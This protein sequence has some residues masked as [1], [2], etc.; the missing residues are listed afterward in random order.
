[1]IS[2][3]SHSR[4]VTAASAVL[5]L[6]G[7]VALFF[8]QSTVE[9]RAG[10]VT[11]PK[12]KKVL[13]IG[14]DGCRSD[15][16]QAAD[17]PRLKA[18]AA[19]GTVTWNAVA[20]GELNGPTQQPTVSGPGWSSILC[21]VCM[22]KHRIFDNKFIGHQLERYP[23]FFRRL[24]EAR[25]ALLEGQASTWAPLENII[26]WQSAADFVDWHFL[27]LVGTHKM[28]DA[29][30]ADAAVKWLRDA[31]PDVLFIHFDSVDEA[32]H[33]T[34]FT[35]ANPEYLA[36]IH[37]VDTHAGELM[38]A[39]RTRQD[40]PN[41]DWL[42]IVVTDHGGNG[43]SHGGQSPGERRIFLIA[44]GG[45]WPKGRVSEDTPRQSAVPSMIAS[46]LD[47]SVPDAWG[48]EPAWSVK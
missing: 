22:D 27:S 44:S 2:S 14:I 18:L 40:Y 34:G 26:L 10:L 42:T 31:S 37:D 45:P 29:Q 12:K 36:A 1:M 17:A 25:P 24:K 35:P 32:G 15:A 30:A 21:G 20:G 9:S 3:P 11:A 38:D 19:E 46:F 28:K 6:A 47:I 48:W 16:L 23:H 4:L 5:V 33:A 43:T 39:I 8:S 13:L 7:V 41:E